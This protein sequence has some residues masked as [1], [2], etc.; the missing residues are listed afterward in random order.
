MGKRNAADVRQPRIDGFGSVFVVD[1]DGCGKGVETEPAVNAGFR[2]L[3]DLFGNLGSEE[4]RCPFW[5]AKMG[6]AR[7]RKKAGTQR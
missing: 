5:G 1:R 7:E 6:D 3:E 2:R 4:K